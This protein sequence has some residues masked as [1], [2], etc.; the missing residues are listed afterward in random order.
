MALIGNLIWVLL[1]TLFIT[2][3]LFIISFIISKYIKTNKAKKGLEIF[4]IL[5]SFLTIFSILFGVV[6]FYYEQNQQQI[7]QEENEKIILG[8]LKE[9]IK[10]NLDLISLIKEKENHYRETDEFTVQRFEYYYLEKSRDIIKNKHL[11]EVI[12]RSIKNIKESNKVMDGFAGN[13]FFPQNSA[14]YALYK[15]LKNEQIGLVLEYNQ[16]IELGL[17]EVKN[18]NEL[19]E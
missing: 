16:A 7:I 12:M 13:L 14:Q 9:E 19:K 1:I 11:R 3:L 8:N 4:Y 17:K 10:T 6:A 5:V 2:L 15:K 18:S